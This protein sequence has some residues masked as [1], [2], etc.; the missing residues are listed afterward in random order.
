[1][2]KN[3]HPNIKIRIITSFMTRVVGTMIFPFMAIYLSDKLG[4]ALAGII[5]LINVFV[6]I[7]VG[8]YGG[9][10]ADRAGRKKVMVIGQLFTVIAFLFM[11]A[12]NSPWY[13]SAWVT[14]FMM[15]IQSIS[16][17]LMN[18]AAEAMLID[19]STKENRKFMY[20]INYWAVNLSIA[21]GSIVGGFLFKS[22]R[23]ELFIAITAVSIITLYLVAYVM[24]ESFTQ[25]VTVTEKIN[26]FKDMAANYQTVMKDQLFLWFCIASTL[27]VGIEFQMGNYISVRLEEEFVSHSV[28]LGD[29]F[30]Y[31]LDGLR[32]I[33]WLRTFNTVLVVSGTILVTRWVRKY[34]DHKVIYTGFWMYTAGY[35]VLGYSNSAILLVVCIF[36]A[37]IGELLYVPVKQSIMADI[38][39]DDARSSYMA[40]QGLTFQVAK[41]LGAA[42]ITIGSFVPSWGMAL[43]YLVSGM[44]GIYCFTKVTGPLNKGIKK[45]AKKAA[46]I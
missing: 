36:I 18:P 22:H 45:A 32:M 2:F 38:V 8:F 5:L 20:S 35:A 10:V 7:L 16:S 44:L 15:L 14:S 23:F 13:D 26:V 4:Q 31:H 42:G 39:N 24:K 41:I 17:G 9:Y 25:T 6:S 37:T 3:L 1:M 43:A 34:S 27:I 46:A 33:S 28:S 40:V 19:V 12:A 11:T 21:L 29:M 30:T